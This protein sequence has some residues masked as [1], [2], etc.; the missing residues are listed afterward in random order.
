[1]AMGGKGR[2]EG[3][4][5]RRYQGGKEEREDE[6]GHFSLRLCFLGGFNQ[7]NGGRIDE[8]RTR[9]WAVAQ[10]GSESTELILETL[11]WRYLEVGGIQLASLCGPGGG[12][13]G[14][15]EPS[16]GS[17]PWARSCRVTT[18]GFTGRSG[19]DWFLRLLLPA[20][21]QLLGLGLRKG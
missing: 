14:T 2:I 3:R 4:R 16:E 19:H 17:R 8:E 20:V 7:P 10:D 12:P 6:I 13:A 21:S 9:H 5:M 18:A 15:R 11:G 1:M